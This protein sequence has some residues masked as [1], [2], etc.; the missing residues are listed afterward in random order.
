M[1]IGEGTPY[2]AADDGVVIDATN[3]GGY[4]GGAGNWIVIDHGNGVVTKY[5]HSA[6]TFVVPGDTVIRGQN[7]GLVGNTGN[8]FG[9]HLHFQVE[10]NGVAVD[11]LIYL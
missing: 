11:P 8:S 10:I 9:S 5:M 4:N 1:A 6:V 2:Y 7:I 3:G